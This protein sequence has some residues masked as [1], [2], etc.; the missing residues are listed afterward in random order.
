[1]VLYYNLENST[2]V[3]KKPKERTNH[4]TLNGRT[5]RPKPV[6][7][8][9]E[10]TAKAQFDIAEAHRQH[11]AEPIECLSAAQVN[12]TTTEWL[13]EPFIPEAVPV[14]LVG[15]TGAGKSTF[16]S[17]VM[18]AVSGGRWFAGKRDRPNQ[19]V[20]LYNSEEDPGRI[21][22]PR[23]EAHDAIL[24]NIFFGDQGKSGVTLARLQLPGDFDKLE[25]RIVKW[26]IQL[27]CI[28]PITAYLAGGVDVRDAQHVRAVLDGLSALSSRTGCN[29]L[30]TTHYRKS[31]EG[32]PLDRVTGS[33]AWTQ[34]PRVVLAFG[35]DPDDLTKRILAAAKN[36][37][38]KSLKSVRYSL[39]TV[40]DSA[41]FVIADE[42]TVT[43][44]DLGQGGMTPGDRDALGDA[45]AYLI[46]ALAQEE[47]PAKDI[48]RTAQESAISLGTLRRAKAKIGVTSHPVG[49]NGSRYLVWRMPGQKPPV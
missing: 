10:E 47:K 41:C 29:I 45:V 18:A 26:R 9:K 15:D 28:D 12:V 4:P 16:M 39:V 43:A 20:L 31:R 42:C 14:L 44:E 36:S 32:A 21:V 5:S 19:R 7:Q 23:L 34:V 8:T 40:G 17:S 27:L 46:D 30:Y 49:A 25:Q 35:F 3:T 38:C 1:V 33:A 13:W 22:R 24:S 2:V 11:L 48:F 6:K 37:L